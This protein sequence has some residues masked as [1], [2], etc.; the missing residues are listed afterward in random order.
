M[1]VFYPTAFGLVNELM[2]CGCDPV[3]RNIGQDRGFPRVHAWSDDKALFLEAEIP[4]A[5]PEK[6]DVSVKSNE[7]TLKGVRTTHR[8][9]EQTFERRFA[10]PPTLKT[11]DIKATLQNGVLEME[12]PFQAVEEPKKITIATATTPAVAATAE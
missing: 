5:D 6:L 4:G 1:K 2:G 12:L 10:L 11:T 7:L 8:A 9:G 3:I